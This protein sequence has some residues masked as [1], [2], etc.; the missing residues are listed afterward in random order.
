VLVS[1]ARRQL[2]LIDERYAG[3]ALAGERRTLLGA[4]RQL[5]PLAGAPDAGQLQRWLAGFER[6]VVP[7]LERTEPRSLYNPALL[8]N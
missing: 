3:A 1:G 8:G 4:S 2:G 6:N 5:Q 7:R